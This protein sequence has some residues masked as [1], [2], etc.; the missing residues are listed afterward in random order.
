MKKDIICKSFFIHFCTT[1]NLPLKVKSASIQ[2][3][4]KIKN[5]TTLDIHNLIYMCIFIA[6]KAEDIQERMLDK[7]SSF[8]GKNLN[9]Q[10]IIEEEVQIMEIIDF[11]FVFPNV[12]SALL[13]VLMDLIYNDNN[14]ADLLNE[15]DKYC[16]DLD[17]VMLLENTNLIETI[18]TVLHMNNIEIKNKNIIKNIEELKVMSKKELFE[19]LNKM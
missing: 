14:K 7:F 8:Y 12:Y 1:F 2:L 10:K 4:D 17:K 3:Y 6:A 9:K 16:Y 13:G 19:E 11:D 5:K 18:S 15:Y